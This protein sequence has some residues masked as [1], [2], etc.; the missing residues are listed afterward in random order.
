MAQTLTTKTQGF[1]EPRFARF[2]FSDPKMSIVWLLVRIYVGWQWLHAGIGKLQSPVWT[3]NKAGTAMAGFV[4]GALRKTTGDHV[5]VQGFYATFLRDVV[6]PHTAL[7]SYAIAYGEVLVGLGL[8]V[9]LFA[10]IAAFFGGLMNANYLLAGTVSTN[11]WLFILATWLVLAWRVAG[12]IGLDR[13]I[14]PA[15]GV[16]GQAGKLFQH[17]RRV[18]RMKPKPES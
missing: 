14:L 8:I 11:P 17:N 4:N 13:F 3:G 15:V 16:P 1:E 5:D 6:L 18:T 12:Y 10:G 7:W 2:I 9:G